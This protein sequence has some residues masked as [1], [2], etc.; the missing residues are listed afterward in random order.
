M[1][2]RVTKQ[3][4]D[5]YTFEKTTYTVNGGKKSENTQKVYDMTEEEIKTTCQ[6][7][8]KIIKAIIAELNEQLSELVSELNNVENGAEK[9]DKA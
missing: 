2:Y 6:G 1:F 9:K 7:E 4:D 5:K 3:K 8:I